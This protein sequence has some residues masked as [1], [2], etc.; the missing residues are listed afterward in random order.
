MPITRPK[1]TR[2]S[3]RADLL[4]EVAER[5]PGPNDDIVIPRGM[6]KLDWEV[7]TGVVI[8]STARY[9]SRRKR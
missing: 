9:V 5:L 7:R 1:L 2:R 4:S 6:K 8:G 3:D